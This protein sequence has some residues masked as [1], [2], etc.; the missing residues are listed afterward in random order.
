MGAMDDAPILTL[1]LHPKVAI[2]S[3][4]RAHTEAHSEAASSFVSTAPKN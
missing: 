3:F 4:S 2:F 1:R